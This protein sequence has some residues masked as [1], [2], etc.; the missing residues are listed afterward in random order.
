MSAMLP[1]VYGFGNA[2]GIRSSTPT[3]FGTA[4]GRNGSPRIKCLQ[5]PDSG[6]THPYASGLWGMTSENFYVLRPT[7]D[8]RFAEWDEGVKFSGPV[9]C[10]EK[11]E[12][13]RP[14]PRTGELRV[15][16]PSRIAEFVWTWYGECLVTDT[17]LEELRRSA[18]T[19]YSERRVH[20]RYQDR[21]RLAPP[22]WELV[23][24]GWGGLAPVSSGIARDSQQSCHACGLDVYTRFTDP[25]RLVDMKQ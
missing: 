1:C 3:Q 13:Q 25:N 22:L 14:G 10:P 16:L 18:I 12:H 23:V 5:R 8:A 11:P 15:V 7:K 17:V 20:T 6:S 24:H 9:R 4:H 21:Q 19:G 2:T